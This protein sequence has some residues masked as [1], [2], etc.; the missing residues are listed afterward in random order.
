MMR[1]TVLVSARM[2]I[3][4]LTAITALALSGCGSRGTAAEFQTPVKNAIPVMV[5]ELPECKCCTEYLPYLEAAGFRIISI[6]IMSDNS[7]REKFPVPF[8]FTSCHI[9][10]VGGYFVE[11]HV[12]VEAIFKL[13]EERPSIDGITLPGMPPGAPGMDGE[14][15][16]PFYIYAVTAGQTSQ[17][18]A[19]PVPAV[20][21]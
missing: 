2:A 18:L 21:Q 19:F 6:D 3:T 1:R 14:Q 7:T 11:G 13:L 16:E 20:T 5:Y 9:M 17:F 4:A 10:S 8:E 12:P 15:T